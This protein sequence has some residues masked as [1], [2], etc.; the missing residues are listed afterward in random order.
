MSAF[1]IATLSIK[2]PE[3]FKE[4]STKASATFSPFGGEVLTRGMKDHVMCGGGDHQATAVVRFPDMDALN[5]WYQSADY[6][7]LIPLR[8]QGSD[9]SLVAYSV[10]A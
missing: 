2:D 8:D 3:V 4:Y 10:P 9:M 7:A 6:Q 1:F 5:N